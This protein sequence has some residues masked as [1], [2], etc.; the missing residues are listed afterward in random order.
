[1]LLRSQTAVMDQRPGEAD[2]AYQARMLAWSTETKK[3]A[4]DAA[5]AAKKK[6]E[7]A[8]QAR[9]LALEQQRQH[10]EAAARAADEERNQSCEKIFSGERAL[11]TMA[12]EWRTEADNGKLED[13]ENKI[14]LL[15]SHLTDLLATCITQQE[16][17][18]SLNGSLAKL[19]SRLQ[20]LERRPVV[21][22]DA[23]SSNTSNRLEALEMH[24]GS[25]QDGAQFQQTAMQQLQ[26]RCSIWG[27]ARADPSLGQQ[28]VELCAEDLKLLLAHPI[29]ATFRRH[30][31]GLKNDLVR[32][33]LIRH[34][35]VR[36]GSSGTPS[37]GTP[38]MTRELIDLLT[39]R[40]RE[41]RLQIGNSY[42]SLFGRY[43]AQDIRHCTNS[44]VRDGLLS[45][46]R[47]VEVRDAEWLHRAMKGLGT[48]EHV[49]REV[50]C[51]RT[52]DEIEKIKAM[53]VEMFRRELVDDIKGDVSGKFCKIL[54]K[55]VSHPRSKAPVE[56]VRALEVARDLY[57][58]TQGRWGVNDKCFIDVFTGES[59]PQLSKIFGLY[60]TEFKE[61]IFHALDK[62]SGEL[63]KTLLY[64]AMCAISTPEFFAVMLRKALG[65]SR[66]DKNA[67]IR[68][69]LTRC[70]IDLEDVKEVYN[71]K[72]ATSTDST[73]LQNA[74]RDA[75]SGEFQELLL[76]AMGELDS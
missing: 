45:L 51:S 11:L 44:H 68:I 34:H 38:K 2:E 22:P 20:Q 28:I 67:I 75:T 59:L 17:I 48:D 27:A 42:R 8:E 52:Y 15:L 71:F 32:D 10:D 4:D 26:Q 25:L 62:I 16:D 23:S 49:L 31:T 76:A 30:D 58:A 12:A 18:H 21:A 70:E 13:C 1:M 37:G 29:D 60:K 35:T 33:R 65:G 50:L 6:A 57:Q 74:I 36:D 73:P 55:L 9:L 64:I 43:L 53:Y 24:V 56:P 47:P 19:Q 40:S 14:A 46:I 66:V 69:I 72:Y 7:D 5:V 41:Q 54:T 3:R 39:H 63:H 61:S